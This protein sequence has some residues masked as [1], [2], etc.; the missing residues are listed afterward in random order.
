MSPA[1]GSP[2]ALL[3]EIDFYIESTLYKITWA[4]KGCLRK[5]ETCLKNE[6][7]ADRQSVDVDLEFY[8]FGGEGFSGWV[9]LANWD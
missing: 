2:A 5:V 3:E 8:E 7:P 9:D 4:D 6:I 1:P